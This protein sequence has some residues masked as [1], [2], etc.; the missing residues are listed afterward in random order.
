MLRDVRIINWI[1]FC[2]P[3]EPIQKR[4]GFVIQ[5]TNIVSFEVKRLPDANHV[6]LVK[7]MD[8]HTRKEGRDVLLGSEITLCS[9][10]ESDRIYRI[11]VKLYTLLIHDHNFSY[12]VFF[13][14]TFIY[15]KILRI[16]V[17]S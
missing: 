16:Y 5:F 11:E 8:I 15:L 4:T 1:H 10:T 13:F 14:Q 2:R 17:K 9:C 12:V 6:V 3:F 7:D